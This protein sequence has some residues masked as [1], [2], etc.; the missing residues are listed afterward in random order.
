MVLTGY[1]HIPQS[2]IRFLIISVPHIKNGLPTIPLSSMRPLMGW[3]A[4]AGLS[5]F[6]IWALKYKGSQFCQVKASP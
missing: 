6:L 5:P 2:V 1:F 3:T 4:T